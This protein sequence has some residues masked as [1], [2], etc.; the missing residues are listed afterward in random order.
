VKIQRLILELE[1]AIAQ[2]GD[3]SQFVEEEESG[4]PTSVRGGLCGRY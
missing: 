2:R 3:A 4:Y 1:V